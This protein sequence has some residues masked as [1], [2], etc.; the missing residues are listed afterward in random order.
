MCGARG[1]AT[2]AHAPRKDSLLTNAVF[3]GSAESPVCR[4]CVCQAALRCARCCAAERV[5]HA[6]AGDAL[7]TPHVGPPRRARR[8]VPADPFEKFSTFDSTVQ[9]SSA[10][11][12]RPA[13]EQASGGVL[14]VRLSSALSPC[15][16]RSLGVLRARA[17]ANGSALWNPSAAA[18]TRVPKGGALCR[19][20]G[21]DLRSARRCAGAD[22]PLA[23]PARVRVP[24]ATSTRR[25]RAATQPEGRATAARV[26]PEK[27]LSCHKCPLVR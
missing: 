21:R 22:R 16:A 17:C 23:P 24:G 26:V 14:P 19:A 6:H 11:L 18:S 12:P 1:G 3:L 13:H 10:L 15:A 8:C 4:R 2:A 27:S 5:T 20:A 7:G 25:A 9:R